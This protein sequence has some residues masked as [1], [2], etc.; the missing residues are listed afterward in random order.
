MNS[1]GQQVLN[2]LLEISGELTPERMKRQS[3]SEK[4]KT[5]TKKK[6]PVLDVTSDGSK[7]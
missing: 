6:H 2:M 1:P 5:K 7:V 3:Q 4:Q